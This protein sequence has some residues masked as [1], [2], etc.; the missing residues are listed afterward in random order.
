MEARV[1]TVG[2]FEMDPSHGDRFVMARVSLGGWI[3][4]DLGPG[5]KT[6]P[7]FRLYRSER[8]GLAG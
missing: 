5:P 3:E 1:R 8:I 2:W 6:N 7:S 4:M